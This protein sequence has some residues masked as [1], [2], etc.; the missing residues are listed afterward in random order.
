M[1]MKHRYEYLDVIRGI[2]L[3]SM[4][5]Y[6][7]VWDM[8]YI[9]DYPWEWFHSCLAYVWQQS[10]CWTFILLSG[11]CWSMG[12]R[13]LR[14]GLLVFGA[15]FLVS[16]VT[17]ILIPQQ[18]VIFGV[19]TLLGVSMLLMIPLDKLFCR[20]PAAV[21]LVSAAMLFVVTKNIN[22]GSLGFE[23]IIFCSL[24]ESWYDKGYLM[25]FLGFMDKNFYST[26][27]FSL[28]P[29]FFLFAVGYFLYW[30]ADKNKLLEKSMQSGL[31]KMPVFFAP[32]QFM[33]RHSLII[34]LLHQPV[35]YLVV[36]TFLK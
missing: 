27:Y 11:F 31:A 5:L 29:W 12:R 7:G 30:L 9:A 22:R 8:V 23:R 3:L 17:I 26:D 6:H 18:R 13:R 10:I 34:Y 21:G 20:I 25:T 19:L 33:G 36:S 1:K 35:I 28:V 4:M 24:P 16:V 2:T 15:G 14:R 32:F